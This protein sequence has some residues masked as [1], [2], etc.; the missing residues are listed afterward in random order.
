MIDKH[1]SDLQDLYPSVAGYRGIRE[2]VGSL[3][4]VQL[5]G[6]I[7]EGVQ[8]LKSEVNN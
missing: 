5:I 7:G 2:E 3:S 6:A 8:Q 4:H 1:T